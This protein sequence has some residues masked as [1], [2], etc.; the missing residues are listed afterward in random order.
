MINTNILSYKSPR[1]IS[2][3]VFWDYRVKMVVVPRLC[4]ILVVALNI[5]LMIDAKQKIG[6]SWYMQV[7][8]N[9][10]LFT[11]FGHLKSKVF[12]YF[13]LCLLWFL[14]KRDW[15]DEARKKF[16]KTQSPNSSQEKTQTFWRENAHKTLEN[17]LNASKN[18]NTNMA[19][20][21]IIFMGDGMS[22]ETVAATRVYMG[23]SNVELSFEKFPY[24]GLSKV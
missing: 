12:W 4:S 10:Y 17:R 24:V 14:G 20:N 7:K 21:V 6:N 11:K 22:L 5:F 9:C 3:S 23:N 15:S 8:K 16:Q 1:L 18:L 2:T 19:K 13:F